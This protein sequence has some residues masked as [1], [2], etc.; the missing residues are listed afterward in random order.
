MENVL[1]RFVLRAVGV[2]LLLALCVCSIALGQETQVL[3]QG[4][5]SDSPRRPGAGAGSLDP[6]A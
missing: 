3:A 2:S 6:R 1:Q 5:V 4:Q